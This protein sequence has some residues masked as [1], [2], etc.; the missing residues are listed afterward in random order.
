MQISFGCVTDVGWKAVLT[1][2]ASWKCRQRKRERGLQVSTK[3]ALFPVTDNEWQ[4]LCA[5]ERI[6]TK[7]YSQ[8][9]K[10]SIT[11]ES[12]VK[13]VSLTELCVSV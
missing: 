8:V 5:G 7:L 3:L 1:P 9:N 10:C 12:T 6:I 2:S 11:D 4:G 13:F